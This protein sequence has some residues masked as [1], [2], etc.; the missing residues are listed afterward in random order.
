MK[1]TFRKIS[2]IGTGLIGGSIALSARKNGLADEIIGIC[3]HDKTVKLAKKLKIVDSISK[4]IKNIAGSD[5]VIFATPVETIKKLAPVVSKLVDKKCVITDVGSTKMSIVR[6]LDSK[7]ENFLGS[8]PLAGSQ[9]RGIAFANSGILKGS[10]CI[11]TPTANTSSMALIKIKRFWRRLGVKTVEM[12]PGQHDA[13][14][15]LTSHLPHLLAFCLITITPSSHFR[16]AAGGFKDTTRIAASDSE[17]WSDIFLNNSSNLIN[18]LD[19]LQKQLKWF[20]NAI[21]KKNSA[22]IKKYINRAKEKR[23]L[24]R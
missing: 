11:L 19:S 18:S 22:A 1:K 4:D 16:F 13:I 10:A 12:P 9:N 6:L 14:V 7:F 8:H 23:I 5:L 20:R 17:I 2:I 15:S 24:L 21:S 3:R